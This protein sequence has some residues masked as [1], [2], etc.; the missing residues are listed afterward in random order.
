ML[1]SMASLWTNRHN[2]LAGYEFNTHSLVK[3]SVEVEHRTFGEVD[4]TG[5]L[6]VDGDALF[7]NAKA[8]LFVLYDFGNLYL[9]P[10]VGLGE[11]TIDGSG[12]GVSFSE[13]Q[14]GYQVGLEFGTRLK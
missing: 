5:T 10:M 2:V 4:N 12:N 14:T 9:A 3:T 7:V 11:V 6:K 13:S 8:K 1:A